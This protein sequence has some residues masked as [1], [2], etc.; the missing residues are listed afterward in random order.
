MTVRNPQPLPHARPPARTLLRFNAYVSLGAG[1]TT[2]ILSPAIAPSF[3]RGAALV[4]VVG[5]ALIA[6][7]ADAIGLALGRRLRRLHVVPFALLEAGL[8]A[9]SVGLLALVPEISAGGRVVLA[10]AAMVF[11]WFAILEFRAAR[12]L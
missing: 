9:G 1:L 3:G 10:V 6:N 7:G 11:G 5:L 2:V 8:A 12:S 4:A